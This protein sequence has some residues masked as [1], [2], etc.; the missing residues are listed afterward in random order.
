[1]R[2]SGQ[3]TVFLGMILLCMCA[4]LC[5]VV[6][7]ARMAGARWHLRMAAGSALD[8]VMA[9]YHRELWESYRLLLREFGTEEDLEEEFLQ[10][11]STYFEGGGW[12]PGNSR[13]ASVRQAARI[14]EEGGRF[15]EQ[16]ILDYMKYGIWTMEFSPG[17]TGD[18]K[19]RLKEAQAVGKTAE[20]YSGHGREAV[21][22]E[23]ALEE[24]D[25]CLMEQK[26]LKDKGIQAL[27]EGNG[28]E[29]QKIGKEL[30]AELE[31]TPRLVEK[32]GKRA[33]ELAEKLQESRRRFDEEAKEMG[34]D[35]RN[36]L[37]QEIAQY[38]SYI[39][40]EGERRREIENETAVAEENRILT[41]A[42]ME[43]AEE[44]EDYIENW[45]GDDEDE[46]LDEEALWRPVRNHFEKF[47]EERVVCPHGIEDKEKKDILDDLKDLIDKGVLALV[48]PEGKNVS[49]K[50]LQDGALPS[51]TS[52]QDGGAENMDGLSVTDR[53]LVNE[54]CG[55]F[56]R[57]FLDEGE[58]PMAY[59]LEYLATGKT[60]DRSNLAE[61]A[62]EIFL[63][64]EGLNLLHILSD[65][66]KR[67]EAQ[68]LAALIVGAAGLGPLVW[69][70]AFL[71]MSLWAAA[72]A[73]S[74]LRI[75]LEGGKVPLWKSGGDW[76]MSLDNMMD[77]GKT[78]Q[79][80][81]KED[82]GR[83]LSYTGYVKLLLFIEN[84]EALYYRIMDMIQINIKEKQ[85]DFLMADC[86]WGVDI[87]AEI[88][89]KHVFLIPGIVE[90]P[91]G[92]REYLMSVRVKRSY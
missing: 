54:Y 58:R 62:E 82:G 20:I 16:E 51:F 36:L 29:F 61:V 86:A 75:L 59:E 35:A 57:S 43:E 8:S 10:Y 83:G 50:Q 56:F 84:R 64:R 13:R 88:C 19:E 17:E 30:I 63:I 67:Q 2:R 11:F 73:V 45:E 15:L 47:R 71:I 40:K 91:L 6:E 46:E 18:L 65:S 74:D 52:R 31:K 9:G 60:T 92:N 33:D 27:D 22:L 37:E 38:Q 87:Q 81:R 21:R 28:G 24:L 12:Y 25:G 76:K 66:Q 41:E 69:V 70:M 78:G 23:E 1:M 77:L 42:V 90:N 3:V 72:E 79:G 89:G 48:V 55:K 4:L 49:E 68:Q 80:E 39:S 5:T 85:E 53:L 32:Y 7:S 26:E 44:V 14:T 34:G